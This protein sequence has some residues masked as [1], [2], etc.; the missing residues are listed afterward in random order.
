M[1]KVYI[2]HC[3]D[4]EGPLYENPTVPF[5]MIK[6]IFGIDIEPNRENLIKL[7]K[8]ELD[9]NGLEEKVCQLVDIHRITTRGS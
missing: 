5:E 2:V 3:V 8:G 1:G 6:N 9:L 4:T 7:Q